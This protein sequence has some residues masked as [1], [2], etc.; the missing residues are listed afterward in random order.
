MWA[1]NKKVSI[2]KGESIRKFINLTPDIIKWWK[3]NLVITKHT[4]CILESLKLWVKI[5]QFLRTTTI[6]DEDKDDE[7]EKK[8]KIKNMKKI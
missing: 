4:K 6:Y 7:I 1:G 2:Y 3:K 8:R 5:S